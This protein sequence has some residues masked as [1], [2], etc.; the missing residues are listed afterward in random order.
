MTDKIYIFLRV[1]LFDARP[2]H[3]SLWGLEAKPFIIST[4]TRLYRTHLVVT[5]DGNVDVSKWG[6]SVAQGN[7]R[8]VDIRSLSQRLMISTGVGHDQETGLPEGCLNLI[9]ECTR[10]EPTVEG[11]GT[12]G[13]GKLQHCP[14]QKGH[15]KKKDRGVTSIVLVNDNFHLQI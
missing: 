14:L 4:H 5:G 2:L 7:G 12:G 1:C 10:S 13:R 3:P 6:V 9:G 8:D 11:G 15:Q